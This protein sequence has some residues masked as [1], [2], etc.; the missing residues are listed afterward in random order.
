MGQDAPFFVVVN[1]LGVLS[2][3]IVLSEVESWLAEYGAR[4]EALFFV[5]VRSEDGG[6]S[7]VVEADTTAGISSDECAALCSYLSEKCEQAGW[8]VALMV[9]S[10]GLTTPLRHIRQYEKSIGRTVEV[11]DAEGTL[12]GEITHVC[13]EGFTLIYEAKERQDGKKRPVWVPR[14]RD[15][16]FSGSQRVTIKLGKR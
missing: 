1:V 10:P 15:Y 5:D 4:D 9:S 7:L 2:M 12:V 13:A 3:G 16:L 8:D 14:T 11:V 6:E